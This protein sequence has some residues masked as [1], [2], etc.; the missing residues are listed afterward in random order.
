MA[1]VAVRRFD[2]LLFFRHVLL[3]IHEM[4]KVVVLGGGIIGQFCAYYLQKSGNQVTIVDEN[5][6]MPPASAGNCGL[7]T[8]SHIAP[9]N[10]WSTL[11]AG[12]KWLGK[13]DAPLSIKPQLNTA[14][15]KWFLSFTWN[16][17]QVSVEK[18]T[19]IR[20]ELLQ[21]SWKLF[22]AFFAEHNTHSE[23]KSE[24]LVY[25]CQ[26]S[27]C[28]NQVKDE[29]DLISHLG[30][31]GNVLDKDA[32]LALEPTISDKV[33]GG[34][35]MNVDGWL[36][37]QQL[38]KD[39]KRINEDSGVEFIEAKIDSISAVQ[40]SIQKIELEHGHIAADEYV[41]CAG[42][43]S[44]Q[45]ARTIG[46]GIPVIPGKGYNLTVDEPLP[47]QP[48]RPI[49]M[50]ERKVV[51]TPWETG[52]RLG[53][54]MEFSGYDLSLNKRRLEALKRAANEYLDM[55]FGTVQFQPWAGWRPMS[56]D[57]IPIIER[58]TKYSNL[59]IATGHSMQGLSMA[60]AT[61]HMVDQI[62]SEV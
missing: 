23:W 35:I 10:T 45:L 13:K 6:S 33:I 27:Q 15:I 39:V 18:S 29:V 40:N 24:G 11:L 19:R 60:P 58:S 7:I 4:K 20:H 34:A 55:D 36:K 2:G 44:S 37:P 51:A 26:S 53:S 61:G 1:I 9:L 47:K 38:L 49:Y 12:L 42:A 56:P 21:S 43:R 14:F 5:H 8:P 46:I 50:V 22:E 30:M 28:W 31:D 62:V 17:R 32:L 3:Y 41:L 59:V 54:T 48:T 57:G 16:C 25:V 52:F